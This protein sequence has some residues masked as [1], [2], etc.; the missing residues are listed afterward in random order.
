VKVEGT[1]EISRSVEIDISLDAA[2]GAVRREI[3]DKHGIPS[4]AYVKDGKICE[5]VEYYGSHRW[6][7]ETVAIESPSAEQIKVL[8]AVKKIE[9]IVWKIH[10]EE[11]KS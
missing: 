6:E 4:D 11:M 3:L 5:T 9:K 10:Q 7:E 2:W 1:E 8:E